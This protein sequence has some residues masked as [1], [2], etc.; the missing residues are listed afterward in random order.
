MSDKNIP[1]PTQRNDIDNK[2]AV[3][4]GMFNQVS[5]TLVRF[6]KVPV[7]AELEAIRELGRDMRSVFLAP[8]FDTSDCGTFI[9]LLK[10]PASKD[11]RYSAFLSGFNE[12]G[13][14]FEPQV[15]YF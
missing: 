13:R 11:K 4:V 5:A 15:L 7:A 10:Q 12:M 9:R 2:S 14:G 6:S 8:S 1:Y 3:L